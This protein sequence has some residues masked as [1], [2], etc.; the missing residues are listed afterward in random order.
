MMPLMMPNFQGGPMQIAPNAPHMGGIR[1]LGPPQ[2]V[3]MPPQFATG[4]M[5]PGLQHA[6]GF[7]QHMLMNPNFANHMAMI[8]NMIQGNLGVPG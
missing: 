1:Q 2:Q 4:F 8:Q 3:P 7:Q 5:P 6:A